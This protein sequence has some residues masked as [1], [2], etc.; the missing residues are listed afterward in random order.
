MATVSP[1][2][3]SEQ[4]QVENKEGPTFPRVT[5]TG[6][7]RNSLVS[8]YGWIGTDG[9]QG[10]RRPSFY[11]LFN[12]LTL[13]FLFSWKD[14]G[15]S[16][17][18]ED[19]GPGKGLEPSSRLHPPHFSFYF[20]ALHSLQ[21]WITERHGSTLIYRRGNKWHVLLAL[22]PGRS[23]VSARLCLKHDTGSSLVD[24]RQ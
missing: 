23:L 4:Q 15:S 24:P 19:R 5:K 3:P 11:F 20:T 1:P 21:S 9:R 7:H 17:L 8:Y 6:S 12:H 13:V 22:D 18:R 14:V 2:P 10:R 16:R